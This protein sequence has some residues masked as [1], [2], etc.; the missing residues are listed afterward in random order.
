MPVAPGA[1]PGTSAP[2]APA[3]TTPGNGPPKAVDFGS[4]N[5]EAPKTPADTTPGNGPPKAGDFNPPKVDTPPAPAPK[6]EVQLCK[7]AGCADTVEGLGVLDGEKKTYFNNAVADFQNKVPAGKSIFYNQGT[8][9]DNAP[10][11]LAAAP[12]SEK[13]IAKLKDYA[14]SKKLYGYQISFEANFQPV[15]LNVL[16]TRYESAAFA[17]IS[18]GKVILFAPKSGVRAG[19]I[20]TDVE[21]PN[22]HVPGRPNPVTEVT[23]VDSDE[24]LGMKFLPRES[25]V[26]WRTG[27]PTGPFPANQAMDKIKF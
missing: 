9:L 2:N 3:D 23:W 1:K 16:P 6:T 25:K 13:F 10:D 20:W 21:W 7:R 22:L 12:I 14:A 17:M 5:G 18:S 26:I 19:S 24:T 4:P 27:Q 15:P 8:T 11:A